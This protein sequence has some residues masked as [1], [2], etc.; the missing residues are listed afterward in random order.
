VVRWSLHHFLPLKPLST[1]TATQK[2]SSSSWYLHI[3]DL[4]AFLLFFPPGNL[5]RRGD[6]WPWRTIRDSRSLDPSVF[7]LYF[8]CFVVIGDGC[9]TC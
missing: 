3:R 5:G 4:K 8:G 9:S 1:D 2:K 7:P 6:L